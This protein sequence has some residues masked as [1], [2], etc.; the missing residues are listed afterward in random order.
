MKFFLR[1][2]KK[3]WWGLADSTS[4]PPRDGILGKDTGL[5]SSI[6]FTVRGLQNGDQ[7]WLGWYVMHKL[8]FDAQRVKYGTPSTSTSSDHISSSFTSH[9]HFFDITEN[10][11]NAKILRLSLSPILLHSSGSVASHDVWPLWLLWKI[12]SKSKAVVTVLTLENS[13]N[14]KVVRT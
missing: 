5:K 7:G 11:F 4:G 13:L 1:M 9:H 10:I 14:Y 3:I 2:L 6:G 8:E 12:H